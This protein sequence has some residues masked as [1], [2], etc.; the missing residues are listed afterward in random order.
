MSL[1]ALITF[2]PAFAEPGVVS[3]AYWTTAVTGNLRAL[4]FADLE[5]DGWEE[6]LGGTDDGQVI[7]WT[8]G[9]Q[10]LW[11]FQVETDWVTGL[12]TTDL[13]GDGFE[14][15]LV[16]AAGILPT[17]YLYVLRLDGTLWW[18]HTVR[19]DLW[20][21]LPYNLDEDVEQELLLSARRPVAL[22]TSGAEIPGWPVEVLRTPHVHLVNWDG[23][24]HQ[25]VVTLTNDSLNIVEAEGA[26]RSIPI[27][28]PGNIQAVDVSDIGRDGLVELVVLTDEALMLLENDGSLRWTWPLRGAPGGFRLIRSQV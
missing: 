8:A 22:D 21:V 20:E 3:G 6:I 14:E 15:V 28:L 23:D 10:R 25:D 26:R 11:E 5:H 16:T 7:L 27:E 19:E 17:S 4:V 12:S 9:G 2:R 13:D 18:S 24:D 1:Y